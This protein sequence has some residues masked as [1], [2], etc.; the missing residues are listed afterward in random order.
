MTLTLFLSSNIVITWMK[1]CKLAIWV[2][3]VFCS[4]YVLC[5]H[6]A[7]GRLRWSCPKEHRDLKKETAMFYI[8]TMCCHINFPVELLYINYVYV[9]SVFI[10]WTALWTP[11][12]PACNGLHT[13]RPKWYWCTERA[14]QEGYIPL[15][16]KEPN[17]C[18][19]YRCFIITLCA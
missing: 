2:V 17:N 13:V 9:N 1:R 16:K 3:A 8:L 11:L 4:K 7:G 6:G 18:Q 14:M 5:F 19:P 15:M 12:Q 10:L